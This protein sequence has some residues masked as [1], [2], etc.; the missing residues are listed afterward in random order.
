MEYKLPEKYKVI[1]SAGQLSKNED[2]IELKNT[3]TRELGD[4]KGFVALDLSETSYLNS[5][6]IGII[7]KLRKDAVSEGGDFILLYPRENV[8]SLFDTIGLS[9]HFPI[10]SSGDEV[11]AYFKK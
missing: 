4:G 3:I 9:R 6:A 2:L 8:N 7:S 1:K 11:E 5:L 10:L